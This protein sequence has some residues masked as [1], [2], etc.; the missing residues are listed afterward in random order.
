MIVMLTLLLSL[1]DVVV[2]V[3]AV[4]MRVADR[5]HSGVLC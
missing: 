2:V 1:D 4:L 5:P 3:L